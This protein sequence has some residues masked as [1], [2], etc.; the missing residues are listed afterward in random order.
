MFEGGWGEWIG[1]LF[2]SCCEKI[3]FGAQRI[4]DRLDLG[5]IAI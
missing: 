2:A 3:A 5:L 1:I 4:Y